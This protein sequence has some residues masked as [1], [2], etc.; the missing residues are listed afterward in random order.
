M[1]PFRRRRRRSL[2]WRI[3]LGIVLTLAYLSYGAYHVIM[4][5]GW[6]DFIDQPL[7]SHGSF[8]EGAFAPLA[9]LWLVIGYFLQYTSLTE[10]NRSIQ[11]QYRAMR[12][13]SAHAA[14]QANA[15]TAS[16][17]HSRRE[18][19]LK[20]LELVNNQLGVTAGLL[21]L[22]NVRHGEQSSEPTTSLW[23]RMSEG[24][25]GMFSR[26]LLD[27]CYGPTGRRR[28]GW[29]LFY[30]TP[31]RRRFT[32]EFVTTFEAV[33]GSARDSDV[34]GLLE[35]AVCRGTAHGHLY[36]TI[37]KYRDELPAGETG[38]PPARAEVA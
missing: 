33:L 31:A 2:D 22:A 5:V 19:F 32:D 37:L 24:D 18:S 27:R 14:V 28:D 12:R 6:S 10:N 17:R 23:S 20:L 11:L 36:R 25:P 1:N 34:D 9:F 38:A 15:I 8:L 21:Y 3:L 4:D 26:M 16:E 7:E 35:Q 30:G 29:R 13:A